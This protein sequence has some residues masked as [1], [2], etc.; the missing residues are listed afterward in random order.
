MKKES[1]EVLVF[2]LENEDY[3][4]SSLRK[5]FPSVGF[6]KYDL[7]KDIEEEGRRLVVVDTIRGI[8]RVLLVDDLHSLNPAKAIDGSGAIMTLRIL[9]SIGSLEA[10]RLIAVPEG[11]GA[12]DA[13][14][15]IR[16]SLRTILDTPGIS[17]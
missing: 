4:L 13:L 3:I 2:G 12:E 11:Y 15:E 7:S 9:L 14:A 1:M 17:P 6:K 16:A 10:V 8:D 5:S